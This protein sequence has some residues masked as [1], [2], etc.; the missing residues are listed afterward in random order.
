MRIIRENCKDFTNA[1]VYTCLFGNYERLNEFPVELKSGISRF[2]FTDNPDL[3]SDTW[4]IKVVKPA[5]EM[6]SARSQ[7]RVKI[8]AHE[9]LDSQFE[10]SLY[11]DNTV[12]LKEKPEVL[13]EKYAQN[14]DMALPYHSHHPTVLDEFIMVAKQGLDEPA[15]IFEQQNHYQ[16]LERDVLSER[17]YWTAILIRFHN[18]PNVK[19]A[20]TDWNNHVCRYS[21]RDQLSANVALSNKDLTLQ[22]IEMD[23]NCE[24]AIHKWPIGF[25]DGEKRGY[26]ISMSGASQ[27]AQIRSM[28]HL[29]LEARGNIQARDDE[30]R[31]LS[32]ELESARKSIN[33]FGG[34]GDLD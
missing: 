23:D 18:R 6:D 5:F 28:Q 2:C 8:L 14:S 3:R 1:C 15:R 22:I 20:M 34:A 31:R 29:L 16:M 19:A 24:S 12:R 27:R 26:N 9:Y 25:R 7:R 21:R 13:F 33:N 10:L 4:N 32:A 17:P 30:I 11:T